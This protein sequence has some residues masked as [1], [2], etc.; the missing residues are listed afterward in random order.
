MDEPLGAPSPL[1]AQLLGMA[2]RTPARLRYE[3]GLTRDPC[4]CVG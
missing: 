2:A 3:H 4:G 1:P